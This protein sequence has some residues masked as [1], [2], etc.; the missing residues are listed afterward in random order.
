MS[1][2][3][4]DTVATV[5]EPPSTSPSRSQSP[6][7]LG[8]ASKSLVSDKSRVKAVAAKIS[9]ARELARRLAEEKQAAVAG[10]RTEDAERL[11]RTT[12][13]AAAQAAAQVGGNLCWRL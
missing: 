3:A 1:T 8:S 12:E 4:K 5:D 6:T 9:A 7:S 2:A 13:E 10:L 11:K